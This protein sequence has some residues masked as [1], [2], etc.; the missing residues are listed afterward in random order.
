M[1]FR[2][3]VIWGLC[4]P[5]GVI[6]SLGVDSFRMVVEKTYTVCSSLLFN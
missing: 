5:E 1:V 3:D 2:R 4:E 6:S